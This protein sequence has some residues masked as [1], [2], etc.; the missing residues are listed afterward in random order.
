MHLY[1]ASSNPGKLRELGA[2]ARGE[3]FELALLPDYDRL[4]PAREDDASFA[5]NALGKALHYSQSSDLLIAADDSGLVV[6]AL[7]G[8][9]G[10]HSARYAGPNATDDDNNRKLLEELGTVPDEERTARFVSVLVLGRA[11][12]PLAL[13]SDSVAGRI[14]HEPRGSGGFGYDPLFFIPWRGCT[15]AELSVEEK[16]QLSH[17]GKAFRKLLAY[18]KQRPQLLG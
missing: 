8:R 13:F 7:D 5:L 4:P 1:L 10:V 16:N 18:L 9:P 2:L 15:S 6:D 12:R 14:L 17:R 3:G 11:G